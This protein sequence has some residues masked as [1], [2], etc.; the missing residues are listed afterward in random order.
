MNVAAKELVTEII[1]DDLDWIP[2]DAVAGTRN[3]AIKVVKVDRDRGRVLFKIRFGRNAEAPRHYHFAEACAITLSG[4][5][6]YDEGEFAAGD[7]AYE[8]AGSDH[9]PT[10]EEGAELFIV[11][12]APEGEHRLLRNHFD[13]GS[14]SDLDFDFFAL[15]EGKS[16]SEAEA[17][18]AALQEA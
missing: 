7:V 4:R 14:T 3:M 6:A 10:S 8:R 11:L 12:L 9:T 2:I 5:W 15:L 18:F 16:A 13:D 17:I 1:R